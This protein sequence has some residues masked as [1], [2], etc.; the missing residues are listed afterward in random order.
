MYEGTFYPL[1]V[2]RL[3]ALYGR[4]DHKPPFRHWEPMSRNPCRWRNGHQARWLTW[5]ADQ[6]QVEWLKIRFGNRK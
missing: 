2:R 1:R 3:Q 5:V 6:Q 4:L